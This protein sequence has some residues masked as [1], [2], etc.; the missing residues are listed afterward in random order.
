M[1]FRI[2]LKLLAVAA[3]P[4]LEVIALFGAGVGSRV[5]ASSLR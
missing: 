1:A 4:R 5:I 2:Y 3:P